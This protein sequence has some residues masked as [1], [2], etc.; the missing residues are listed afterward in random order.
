VRELTAPAEAALRRVL[1][2]EHVEELR[3][4][5]AAHAAALRRA[6]ADG[7]AVAA[8]VAAELEGQLAAQREE[9]LRLEGKM[10]ELG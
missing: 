4:R 6:V 1:E 9:I 7:P 5:D 10:R 8:A 3:R 2:A